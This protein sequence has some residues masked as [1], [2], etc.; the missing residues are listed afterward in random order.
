MNGRCTSDEHSCAT[1][2]DRA[3][4]VRIVALDGADAS[5][6]FEDG[7]RSTVAVDLIPG[8]RVGDRVLVHQ[9]VAIAPA[10][11]VR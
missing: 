1:C 3:D 4:A 8:I 2:S 10:M 5:V 6:E 7:S 9:G 11:G